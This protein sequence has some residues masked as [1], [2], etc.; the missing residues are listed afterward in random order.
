[1]NE[2]FNPGM[3]LRFRCEGVIITAKVQKIS[4][5]PKQWH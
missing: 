2:E 4:L 1:M 5:L 3:G